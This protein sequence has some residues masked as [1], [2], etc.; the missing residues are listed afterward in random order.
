M[1]FIEDKDVLVKRFSNKLTLHNVISCDTAENPWSNHHPSSDNTE[2]EIIF[3]DIPPVV[4]TEIFF[5]FASSVSEDVNIFRI[6]QRKTDESIITI[7]LFVL[8]LWEKLFIT[9]T[10]K[11]P[12]MW[13]NW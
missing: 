2:Y 8:K 1:T 10:V 12:C 11:N 7:K 4:F 6:N 3:H 13:L 5:F 9:V